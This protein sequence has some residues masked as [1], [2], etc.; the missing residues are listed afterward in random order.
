MKN[1]KKFTLGA[2]G[3]TLLVTGLWACSNDEISN[4]EQENNSDVANKIGES[5]Y[6][7]NIDNGL[8]GDIL[9]FENE[10]VFNQIEDN[11]F[12]NTQ[13]YIQ[14][15][16]DGMPEGLSEEEQDD[17][18]ESI[19]FD[20]DKFY[21]QFEDSFNFNS[22]RKDLNIKIDDWLST[23]TNPEMIVDEENDPDNHPLVLEVHRTLFNAGGEIIVLD[24]VGA[25]VIYKMFEWGSLKITGLDTS[26][27]KSINISKIKDY[28]S[29]IELVSNNPNYIIESPAVPNDGPCASHN[30]NHK[31]HNYSS[32]G[33]LVK[34]FTKQMVIPFTSG[35]QLVAKT[36]GYRYSSKRGYY[37]IKLWLVT[38]ITG[39][40]SAPNVDAELHVDGCH[41]PFRLDHVAA[42]SLKVRKHERRYKNYYYIYLKNNKVYS[43][44]G[45]GSFVFTK[46][47]YPPNHE[48]HVI[49]N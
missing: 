9:V 15:V 11:L 27:L 43:Y 3:A 35:K 38:G 8:D 46:D 5:I 26:I 18:L 39:S 47:F 28:T 40:K 44:H 31:K 42:S 17:Y 19:G 1:I 32:T 25:P 21:I 6:K 36:V 24:T 45:Q 12:D 33:T 41:H 13:S 7:M 10:S 2:I 30:I 49:S 23:Q 29:V 48:I 16:M 34:S 20:E 22:L 14:S 4:T 37:R